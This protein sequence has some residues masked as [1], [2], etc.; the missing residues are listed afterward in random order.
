ID[1]FR[2]LHIDADAVVEAVGRVLSETALENVRLSRALV[3]EVV[4]APPALGARDAGSAKLWP[5]LQ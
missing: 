3:G 2:Y 4:A 1:V 5:P